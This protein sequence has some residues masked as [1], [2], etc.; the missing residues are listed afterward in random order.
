MAG[1]RP[2]RP[3]NGVQSFL[4]QRVFLSFIATLLFLVATSFFLS[5]K[6][7][8]RPQPIQTVHLD[9]I[10][11]QA[12]DHAALVSSYA[13]YSRRLKIDASRQVR[14]FS[15]LAS[16]LT[17]LASRVGSDED[18]LRP[19]E[20]EAKDRVK[21]ARQL[22][23][24][25]KEAFDTQVKI[26]K[27]RDTIFSVHEQLHR[28][29]KLGDL[30]SRIAASSTPK[31]LH[32]LAMR[33]MEHRI[34]NPEDSFPSI[35]ASVASDPSLYHYAIFSDNIIAV[36]VVVNSVIRN[37]ADPSRHVFHVVTD[38][39]Y[40]PAMQVWFAKRP[41]TGGAHMDLHSTAEYTFLDAS[42]SPV[43]RQIETGKQELSL[44][45]YLRF[46]LPEIFPQLKKI[47]LLEDDVVVQKD[48][49]EL[50][51]VD[52]QG[53][54]NGAVEMCFGGFRR[55]NRYLNFTNQVVKERFSPRA[56]AWA[57]G[58]NVFDLQAWRTERCTEQFHQYQEMNED[59]L[60]WKP[61][62]VLPAGLMTFYTTTK[63]LEKSWHVMGL[64]YNP[65]VSP[66]EI[67]KAAVLH[68]NGNMKPWLDVA[69]NQ[70]KQL[71][72]KYVDSDMEFLQLC[73][74]GL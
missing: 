51:R 14:L 54:V 1:G 4:T 73:N 38:P 7:A 23:S 42:Y 8:I 21:L 72:T 64:G 20:K 40:L 5:T 22:V 6:A 13:T 67:R 62:T 71:W 44:L 70:Y 49:A 69:M 58:V 11:R 43:I 12:A 65:S 19:V 50:W 2:M 34:S 36:S 55:Y 57:Y 35:P 29:R 45:H 31:S 60:L 30:S 15:N 27:L 52:L 10:R 37:A 63:P 16:S 26:Q 32:C 17:D 74:F 18:S 28:A 24:E 3:I 59:G 39:M 66:E 53:N 9:L 68:F 33:L 56:C 47:I 61:N 25:S 46:Y 48:L 41:P